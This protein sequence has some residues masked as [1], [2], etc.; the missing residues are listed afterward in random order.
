[1]PGEKVCRRLNQKGEM[2]PYPTVKTSV[3]PKRYGYSLGV[4]GD[5]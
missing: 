2:F 1:M 3:I 4:G 5:R